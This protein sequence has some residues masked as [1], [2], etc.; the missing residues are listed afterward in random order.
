MESNGLIEWRLVGH[1]MVPLTQAGAAGLHHDCST[2]DELYE[3]DD[4]ELVMLGTARFFSNAAMPS[5]K[6]K[7]M[8][9]SSSAT[10]LADV[11][12]MFT[13]H[14]CL[15]RSRWTSQTPTSGKRTALRVLLAL[16]ASRTGHGRLA[17]PLPQGSKLQSAKGA[18]GLPRKP[19][20]PKE[21]DC[22]EAWGFRDGCASAMT[23]TPPPRPLRT[24]EGDDRFKLASEVR[25]GKAADFSRGLFKQVSTVGLLQAMSNL[26]VLNVSRTPLRSAELET[27]C[28]AAPGLI[29]IDASRCSLDEL[30][31]RSVFES[32]QNVKVAL[33]HQNMIRRW[34][35]VLSLCGC[36]ALIW[37]TIFQNPV[38]GDPTIRSVVLAEKP[39]IL[40]VDHRMVT[41][42]ERL[43]PEWD[44]VW[45]VL[46]RSTRF[47]ARLLDPDSLDLEVNGSRK[48]LAFEQK[49]D[50]MIHLALQE[51]RVME[52]HYKNASPARCIQAVWR[53][54]HVRRSVEQHKVRMVQAVKAL[55]RG[56]RRLLWRKDMA[57]Y[58]KEYLGEIDELDL[59]L[60]AKEMLRRRALKLIEPGSEMKIIPV[61]V[62]FKHSG[63]CDSHFGGL[64][65]D[66]A[67]SWTVGDL[68]AR[69][70]EL[71][72][73][74]LLQQRLV[75]AEALEQGGASP[76]LGEGEFLS[77]VWPPQEAQERSSARSEPPPRRLRVAAVPSSERQAAW[78]RRV[79]AQP[80]ALEEAPDVIR[81]DFVVV[82]EA[83]RC[84]GEALQFASEQLRKD[85]T[86]VQ[87]AVRQSGAALLYAS[88]ELRRD[89]GWVLELGR[90]SP[91]A[92]VAA[93][94]GP[95]ATDRAFLVGAVALH[96][97]L[98]SR[99][100]E[101][102]RSDR[103]FLL[104]VLSQRGGA[105]AAFPEE[106]RAD[107]EM[108]MTAVKRF[109]GALESASE[110]LREDREVVQAAVLNGAPV[111]PA[112]NNDRELVL[113]AVRLDGLALELASKELR[114]DEEVVMT[115]VQQNGHG[116]R[117]AS[118]RLR[119]NRAFVLSAVRAGSASVLSHVS[120]RLR[121]DGTFMAL[122]AGE[123]ECHEEDIICHGKHEE[124][125]LKRFLLNE[126]RVRR[127]ILQRSLQ[128]RERKAAELICRHA[129]SCLVRR[130]LL[131]ARADLYQCQTFYFPE[132]H[133]WE[134]HVLCNLVLRAHGWPSLPADHTFQDAN[135]LGIRFPEFNEAPRRDNTLLRFLGFAQRVVLRPLR[136][137][138]FPA[139]WDGP[140]HRLVGKNEN[141]LQRNDTKE[142]KEWAERKVRR[143]GDSFNN[144]CRR[145][146][147]NSCCPG[148]HPVRRIEAAAQVQEC[149]LL[150]EFLE[151]P[152]Q[153]WPA[154]PQ[155]DGV[156]SFCSLEA[157]P[158]AGRARPTWPWLLMGL[159]KSKERWPA[160]EA[161]AEAS[162][163]S[164]S[165]SLSRFG[166]IL[167]DASSA[168]LD[169][170]PAEA[171]EALLQSLT[172]L[173]EQELSRSDLACLNAALPAAFT[174]LAWAQNPLTGP[175]AQLAFGASAL[176]ARLAKLAHDDPDK[177]LFSTAVLDHLQLWGG[178]MSGAWYLGSPLANQA[179]DNNRYVF[180]LGDLMSQVSEL[181]LEHRRIWAELA[182]RC[183]VSD[184]WTST[185]FHQHLQS[186]LQVWPLVSEPMARLL[187]ESL[188]AG[189]ESQSGLHAVSELSILERML[190][191]QQA[192]PA[193]ANSWEWH[194]PALGTC[195]WQKLSPE[196]CLAAFMLA[197]AGDHQGAVSG[198][199]ARFPQE[200]GFLAQCIFTAALDC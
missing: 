190:R 9:S 79:G 26:L 177:N 139:A 71:T 65:F 85:R 45:S 134:F 148:P 34:Q 69:I 155:R 175:T 3:D 140:F 116:I 180:L 152:E 17:M 98:L 196:H 162:A 37:L 87:A 82:L 33:F 110:E 158:A 4:G 141:E 25:F 178:L 149:V 83:V 163:A 176:A 130:R 108:V 93:L 78:Q 199:L 46:S 121:T 105:L 171:G 23:A 13:M 131:Y 172:A 80:G 198:L 173:E 58:V 138:R 147:R 132:R 170:L 16:L 75:L 118:R 144:R 195:G 188:L 123:S 154:E 43:G 27:I 99:L 166:Q 32:L 86:L 89:G 29:R 35:D 21:P 5:K 61:S 38:A 68:R 90:N 91:G 133:A 128:R 143:R 127:W 182:A 76:C 70:Q 42:P 66:A 160:A 1:T 129:R 44:V 53:G 156:Q 24:Q 94:E 136:S 62:E 47:G 74:P 120:V 57:E 40:A 67:S 181:P 12:L 96:P 189:K 36:P 117:W 142:G 106:A 168:L 103:D 7:T 135:V 184:L 95:L 111:P 179:M 104:E 101:E 113:E 183:S 6:A 63:L 109:G 107:K 197:R 97:M 30:P 64:H 51:I 54:F 41:E 56:A 102:I 151:G 122:M 81:D 112:F 191:F 119:S 174:V 2:W 39:S 59:L 72:E 137:G 49:D 60:D 10:A 164:A 88:E 19:S 50:F 157:P 15:S 186:L 22:A 125:I 126:A 124:Q 167:G 187:A 161:E 31:H 18:R 192:W 11:T 150:K 20:A 193:D 48:S 55:Q 100:G 28:T 146:F 165:L 8:A 200:D 77:G 52:G 115:A 153:R 145:A 194:G 14:L 73:A 114:D 169:G 92:L 185:Y 159:R 84:R